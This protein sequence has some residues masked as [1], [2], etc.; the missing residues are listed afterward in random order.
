MERVKILDYNHLV[1][2]YVRSPNIDR[3]F[4]TVNNIGIPQRIE[5]T[6]PAYTIKEIHRIA[7]KGYARIGVCFDSPCKYRKDYF[8]KDV[9]GKDADVGYK[10]G[11]VGF[12]S[13]IFEQIE[14]TQTL[15]YNSGVSIY[16]M[17][18]Y[19][20]D[21]LVYSLV[22]VT[23]RETPDAHIDIYTN[24]A[25]LLP[26]VSDKVSVFIRNK[27]MTW[28]ETK[29]L[30][31]RGYWQ[32]TPYNYSE[33][34]EGLSKMKKFDIPYNTVLLF[35]LLRG[36][37]ADCI[38]KQTNPVTGRSDYPPKVYNELVDILACDN[39]NKRIA[40]GLLDTL[41]YATGG[42]D[43]TRNKIL[44]FYDTETGFLDLG[45]VFRYGDDVQL[46]A[47]CDIMGE[48]VED[49]DIQHI[50]YVFKGMNLRHL[51]L[52][53]INHYQPGKLAGELSNLQINLPM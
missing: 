7:Q 39:I 40:A 53:P 18:D 6:I 41:P 1:H 11:R 25:D 21:D 14:L 28:A 20:A 29:D 36:D 52:Y 16:K 32:V 24:D 19:E 10:S 50:R 4:T 38:P 48:Y 46:D 51:E 5:T 27:R 2:K 22:N 15:L 47:I 44:S 31:R 43:E 33:F 34:C 26:L 12:K 45:K 49:T 13:D 9:N 42:F 30:E 35:K 3:L 23:Q 37:E 8:S 17:Q